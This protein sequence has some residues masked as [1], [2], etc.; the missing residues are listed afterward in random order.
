MEDIKL[1]SFSVNTSS[2]QSCGELAKSSLT[3]LV[4]LDSFQQHFRVARRIV[5]TADTH[6]HMH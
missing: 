2:E 5:P 1:A 4:L 6:I 3:R